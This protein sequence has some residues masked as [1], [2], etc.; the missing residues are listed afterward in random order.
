MNVKEFIKVLE[1]HDQ[2][3]EMIVGSNNPELNNAYISV[4]FAMPYP[5]AKE[6]D[7]QCRDMMDATL[8][9]T[10]TWRTTEGNKPV[11]IIM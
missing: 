1:G 5:T 8:Y 11:V 7:T 6:V 9:S 10:K 2:T 3:A 4:T